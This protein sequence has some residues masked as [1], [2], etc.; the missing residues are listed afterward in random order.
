MFKRTEVE[1]LAIDWREELLA[2]VNVDAT[3]LRSFDFTQAA[4]QL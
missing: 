4:G 2:L 1:K 3:A